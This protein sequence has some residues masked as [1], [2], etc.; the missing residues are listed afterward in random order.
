M[1][2]LLLMK[3]AKIINK[4]NFLM[5]FPRKGTLTLYPRNRD[6]HCTGTPYKPGCSAAEAQ[7]VRATGRLV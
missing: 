3:N 7:P 2:P 1:F 5:L 6:V 4:N